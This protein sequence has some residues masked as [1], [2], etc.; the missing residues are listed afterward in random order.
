MYLEYSSSQDPN[1]RLFGRFDLPASPRPLLV[2]MHGWHGQVKRPHEDN[3]IDMDTAESPW[4]RGHFPG[5][6]LLPGVALLALVCRALRDGPGEEIEIAGFRH[7]RFK[8]L[9]HPGER[10]AIEARWLSA[11]EVRF[12]VQVEGKL[13]CRGT[14]LVRRPSGGER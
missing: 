12:E 3:V 2:Q 14:L 6:P 11:E 8:R 1:L 5:Q 9:V 13:A 4:F 10:I 7:V